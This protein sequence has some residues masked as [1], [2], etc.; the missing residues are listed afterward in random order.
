[1]PGWEFV[2]DENIRIL[3]IYVV[4]AITC[5]SKQQAFQVRTHL[6]ETKSRSRST[7]RLSVPFHPLCRRAPGLGVGT[8][9]KLTVKAFVSL[10]RRFVYLSHGEGNVIAR[11]KPTDE[12]FSAFFFCLSCCK[13]NASLRHEEYIMYKWR[14]KNLFKFHVEIIFKLP[15]PPLTVRV[16][17]TRTSQWERT[18]KKRMQWMEV[19]ALMLVNLMNI[20]TAESLV[21]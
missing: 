7:F 6:T 4:L 3:T 10:P 17:G 2:Q 5:C 20:I 12:Y 14:E 15:S 9:I 19:F 11:H 21:L 8:L 16:Y 13:C 18:R 1:M